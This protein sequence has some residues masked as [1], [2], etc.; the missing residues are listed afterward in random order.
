MAGVRVTDA[1]AAQLRACWQAAAAADA[2]AGREP[3]YPDADSFM[4]LVEQVGPDCLR[5]VRSPF[6]DSRIWWD[7][8][9]LAMGNVACMPPCLSMCGIP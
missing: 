9:C 6:G 1:A 4:E 8:Y 7:L 2:A 5:S 3:L